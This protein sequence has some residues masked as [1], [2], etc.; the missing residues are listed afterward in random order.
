VSGAGALSEALCAW[1]VEAAG[2]GELAREER[3]Q[4][5]LQA[6]MGGEATPRLSAV[7]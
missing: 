3:F 6:A 5:L 2:G 7:E 4:R 1:V